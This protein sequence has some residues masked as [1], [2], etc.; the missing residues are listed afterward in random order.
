MLLD[1]FDVADLL[2]LT[3]RQ[4]LRLVRRGE[5]P[6]IRL[7]VPG[8]EIRFDPEDIRRWVEFHKLPANNE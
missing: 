6:S 5:L 2:G 1:K 3:A 4:V 7:P 8:D